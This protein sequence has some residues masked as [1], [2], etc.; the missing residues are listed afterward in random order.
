MFYFL[1]TFDHTMQLK[2]QISDLIKN[3]RMLQ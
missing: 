2:M 3:Y 1:M